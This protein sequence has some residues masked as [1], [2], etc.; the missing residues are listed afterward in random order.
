MVREKQ[1]RRAEDSYTEKESSYTGKA[2]TV[3]HNTTRYSC[4][5]NDLQLST[6]STNL[7]NIDNVIAGGSQVTASHLTDSDFVG[8]TVVT[9]KI[10]HC[11]GVLFY[12]WPPLKI[13]AK[14]L[15]NLSCKCF[16]MLKI[17]GRYI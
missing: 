8:Q 16:S 7:Q 3:G 2:M 1:R 4:R 17:G 5:Y 11:F 12:T 14:H 15:Q 10:E 9:C 6:N 13:F